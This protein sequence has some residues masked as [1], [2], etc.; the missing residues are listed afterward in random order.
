MTQ[1]AQPAPSRRLLL[2][3]FVLLGIVASRASS[4]KTPVSAAAKPVSTILTEITSQLH[5]SLPAVP[6]PAGVALPIAIRAEQY[7]IDYARRN[8]VPAIGGS[9]V[10][11]D[12]DGDGRPDLYVIVPGGSNHLLKNLPDGTF[13]DVTQKA[14]VAGSGA[15]LGAAFADFDKSGKPSL[16]VAG[17][18]G[19][20]LYRNNGDGSFTDI[21]DKAGLRLK[22]GELATSV[23]PLDAD[24]D[25]YLDL[26]VTVYADLS[27]PPAKPAFSFPNDFLGANSHLFR[28]QHD[29]TFQDIS[30]AAG[31]TSNPGR[32]HKAVAA[33]FNRSGRMDLLLLRDNKPPALYRNQGRGKFEDQTWNAG[34]DIWKYAYVDAQT[35]DFK[36]EGKTDV[37]LWSTVGNEVLLNQGNGKFKQDEDLPLVYAANR[38]FGFHGTA[39]DLSGDGH[40]DLLTVDNKENWHFLV[41][42]GGEFEEAP[43]N[44]LPEAEAG[45][46]SKPVGVPP[47]FAFVTAARLT[48]SGKLD[49]IALTMDGRMRIFEERPSR[50]GI[51]GSRSNGK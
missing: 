22:P 2:L 47:F 24:N 34:T 13:V 17:L 29:G 44:L 10:V 20:T 37:V 48:S 49:L 19:V 39:A 45:A 12:F 7:S 46:E 5:V 40:A 8:L 23:L 18:G 35:G 42:R 33:D 1:Y 36:H 50:E 31:L 27:V 26:L 41:N 9:V 15:D 51:A 11:G 32:T 28:N 16:F 14:K 3:A 25:G 30:E 21:S 6:P 43:I 38:A 4:Q